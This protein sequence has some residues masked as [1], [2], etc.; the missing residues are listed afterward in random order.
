MIGTKNDIERVDELSLMI[1]NK[2]IMIFFEIEKIRKSII[3][4]KIVASNLD[5]EN[6]RIVKAFAE[7]LEDSVKN[8]Q[9]VTKDIKEY[10]KELGEICKKNRE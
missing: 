8:L 9:I 4:L 1:Y 10:S 7:Y 3:N 5:N 2:D 6:Q